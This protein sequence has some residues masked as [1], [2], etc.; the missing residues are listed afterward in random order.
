VIP[1]SG[2]GLGERINAVDSAARKAGH[3]RLLFVGSDA[4]TLTP[5][6]YERASA[7]LDDRDVVLGIAADG[8]VTMMGSSGPWPDL[9]ALPWS[10]E[11]LADALDRACR[12]QGLMVSNFDARYDVDRTMDL[13]RL[14]RDLADDDRPARRALV[15]WL[16]ETGLQRTPGR[17]TISL[18]VPVLDDADALRDLLGRLRNLPEQPF[19]IV[20]AD[21]SGRD[22]CRKICERY[23]CIRLRTKPGRGHQL[24]AGAMRASGD[25]IWFLHADTDPPEDAIARIRDHLAAGNI[26]GFFRF[27]FAGSRAWYKSLLAMLINLRCRFGIPYGDQG[28]FITRSAYLETGGFADAPLFEEVR[29][30]RAA[31]KA[32]RFS[33]VDAS[34]GVSPR[35]W[36]RDGWV[37]RT[38]HNRWLALGHMIGISPARL[39]RS[40][41]QRD[42][43][44]TARC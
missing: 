21:A 19:E 18:V 17:P 36:E 24:H 37:K 7:E 23:D 31:R 26:G 38:L 28:L 1:Q 14:L 9:S 4:P 44:R 29:F 12:Q 13:E 20:I 25:A 10:T 3:T 43:K 5:E 33:S 11:G 30:V 35:R 8:G 34:V 2:G 22:G 42:D 32:G 15:S 41:R 27:R 39:A 40:Y 16:R 6:D